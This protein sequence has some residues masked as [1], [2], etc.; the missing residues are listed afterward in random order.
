MEVDSGDGQ[1]RQLDI[2]LAILWHLPFIPRIQCLYMTEEFAKQMT[3]HKNGK[4]YNP[5][6]MVHAS[7][8]EA[9]KHFDAIHCEKAEEAHN[10][11]VALATDGFNPYG[12]SAAPYTC[13]PMFV[14]PINLPLALLE[15]SYFFRQLCAKELSRTVV[16][17][18]ERLAP[19]LLCKLEKIFPPG[20]LNPM[21]HLILHLP[22]EARMGGRAGMLVLSNQDMSK[23]YSKEM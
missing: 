22:Y 16:A 17:D 11:R 10:V 6:K 18:L 8:G 21:Q 23:D 14:I 2:P 15:L 5:D 4:R 20:F 12:M 1:K 13:W 7:D 19:V 3:W 9:W